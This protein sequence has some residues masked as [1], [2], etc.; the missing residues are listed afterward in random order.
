MLALRLLIGQEASV[1]TVDV[2]I[3]EPSG[4]GLVLTMALNFRF[5]E[6]RVEYHSR[7]TNPISYVM[8]DSPEGKYL[9]KES[10]S[11]RKPRLES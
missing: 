10:L 9:R 6:L 5:N 11:E 1:H 3:A 7:N 4:A 2:I 8:P